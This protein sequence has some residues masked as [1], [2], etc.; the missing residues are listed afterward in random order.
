MSRTRRPLWRD[1]VLWTMIVAYGLV[2]AAY[3]SGEAGVLDQPPV[4]V[5][6]HVTYRFLGAAV[7][8]TLIA[9]PLRW[10]WLRRHRRDDRDV[11]MARS[12]QQRDETPG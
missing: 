11:T 7:T 6:T 10:L 9:T 4:D 5:V 3:A 2:A 1:H 8:M 12:G